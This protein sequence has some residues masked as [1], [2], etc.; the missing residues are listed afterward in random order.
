M[1]TPDLSGL[2]DEPRVSSRRTL[3]IGSAWSIPV[4]A[5]AVSTPQVAASVNNFDNYFQWVGP[6]P[7][8]NYDNIEIRNGH[9]TY[10]GTG[11]RSFEMTIAVEPVLNGWTVDFN[12]P[13]NGSFSIADG[14][15]QDVELRTRQT[16]W[17]GL[18]AGPYTFTMLLTVTSGAGLGTV[19]TKTWI[20][21][22][23]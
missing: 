12:S 14:G 20:V 9:L 15:T 18:P 23:A 16:N 4:I 19:L 22:K 2:P 7:Q 21:T 13:V 17:A 1:T 6:E 8:A 11:L 3:L 5:L 10:I